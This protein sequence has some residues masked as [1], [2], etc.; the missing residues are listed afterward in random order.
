M[1]CEGCEA[2]YTNLS[3]FC[4]W[5][6]L[7]QDYEIES[8]QMQAAGDFASPERGIGMSSSCEFY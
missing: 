5:V 3:E 8:E 2:E 1:L 7:N 4:G 6:W